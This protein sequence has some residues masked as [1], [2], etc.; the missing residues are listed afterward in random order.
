MKIDTYRNYKFIMFDEDGKEV[1]RVGEVQF[2]VNNPTDG[3]IYLIKADN[4]YRYLVPK[5]NILYRTL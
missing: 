2:A 5:E 1:E 4:G 3:E